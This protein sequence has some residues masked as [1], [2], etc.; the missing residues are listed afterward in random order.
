MQAAASVSCDRA[1]VAV[2]GHQCGPAVHACLEVWP[3]SCSH[4]AS[5]ADPGQ[6]AGSACL[7]GS[8]CAAFRCPE[9]DVGCFFRLFFFFFEDCKVL[10][11]YITHYLV[12]LSRLQ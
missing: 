4:S 5:E 7:P 9:L 11:T 3:A 2:N 1:A 12:L 6:D 8:R 10:L